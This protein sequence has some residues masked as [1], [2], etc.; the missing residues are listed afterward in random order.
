ML[1]AVCKAASTTP[2]TELN[3]RLLSRA[4]PTWTRALVGVAPEPRP[5]DILA[6]TEEYEDSAVCMHFGHVLGESL[7][8]AQCA[9]RG[10]VP[11]RRL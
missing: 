9:A 7:R 10:V 1:T 3:R 5:A 11:S 6:P 8:D 4:C 2:A